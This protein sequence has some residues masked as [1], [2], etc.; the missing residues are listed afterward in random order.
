M[1]LNKANLLNQK[2]RPKTQA[3]AFLTSQVQSPR[4]FALEFNS[5]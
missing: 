2:I 5:L 3:V 1:I 4:Y